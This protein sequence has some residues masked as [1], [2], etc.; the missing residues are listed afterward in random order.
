MSSTEELL[1]WASEQ[2]CQKAVEALGKKGF[3][4]IS[5]RNKQEVFDYIIKEAS[6]AATVG[7]G[8]SLTVTGLNVVD[9]LKEMGKELLNHN[10]PGLSPEEKLAI[11]HRQSTL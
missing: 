8:G 3:T 11:L 9:T 4:A 2:K 7:F 5:C 10:V 6:D 1:N